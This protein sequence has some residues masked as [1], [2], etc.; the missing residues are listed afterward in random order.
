M[1]GNLFKVSKKDSIVDRLVSKGYITQEEARILLD[2]DIPLYAELPPY[3]EFSKI[4]NKIAED[5]G[6]TDDDIDSDIMAERYPKLNIPPQGYNFLND[7]L[8]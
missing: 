4:G 8:W 1:E 2:I 6:L 3:V 7:N 5:I